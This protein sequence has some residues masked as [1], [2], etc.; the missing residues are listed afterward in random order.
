MQ[1]NSERNCHLAATEPSQYHQGRRQHIT[2]VHHRHFAPAIMRA[3]NHFHFHHQHA[4]SIASFTN[5]QILDVFFNGNHVYVVLEHGGTTLQ[6]FI[7]K[8]SGELDVDQI[9]HI[10]R[11]ICSAMA[12]LHSCRVIHRDL[13]PENVLIDDNPDSPTYLHVRI[14]DFGLSRN[15]ELPAGTSAEDVMSVIMGT[16]IRKSRSED[17]LAQNAV[18]DDAADDAI[19]CDSNGSDA[20]ESSGAALWQR[21]LSPFVVS[22]PY[23]APEVILCNGNY[24]QVHAETMRPQ[25]PMLPP[26]S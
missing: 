14:I 20:F 21:K 2:I 13:K 12:Y 6:T 19:P 8:Q 10:S 23:R 15:V 22:R 25:L 9:R 18:H 16:P 1:K 24:S 4:L 11:Q 3:H 17:N 7:K 5:E 26:P